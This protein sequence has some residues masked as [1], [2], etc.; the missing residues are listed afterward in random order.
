MPPEGSNNRL[1]GDIKQT[2]AYIE[3]M[4]VLGRTIDAV[5]YT[6]DNDIPPTFDISVITGASG[7]GNV[8]R[9]VGVGQ[10]GTGTLA[11]TQQINTAVWTTPNGTLGAQPA[12]INASVRE[13][14]DSAGV[15][16]RQDVIDNTEPLL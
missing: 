4:G 9:F 15:A 7:D 14:I 5:Q 2:P 12:A 1:A 13:A 8:Q 3:S 11:P 6:S 10:T 16:T